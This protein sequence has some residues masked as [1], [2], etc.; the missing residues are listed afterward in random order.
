[1]AS[2]EHSSTAVAANHEEQHVASVTLEQPPST[3]SLQPAP[4]NRS[5]QVEETEEKKEQDLTMIALA[6][7]TLDADA[8]SVNA[9]SSESMTRG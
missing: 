8:I 2:N 4:S 6:G 7:D 9:K 1:M 3:R 5:I